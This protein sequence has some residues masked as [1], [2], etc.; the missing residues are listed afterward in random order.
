M[1]NFIAIN[2]HSIEYHHLKVDDSR[3]TLVFLHEGLGCIQMWRDFPDTVANATGCNLLVYN[4][5]GY[6]DSTQA[7]LPRQVRYMHDEA[8]DILPAVL[9]KLEIGKHIL[10]GHSDGGSIA[11]INGGGAASPN[12]LGIVT[13]AAHV[14][15]EAVCVRSIEEVKVAYKTTRLRGKLAKYHADVDNTFWGWNDI[16]LHPDFWHWNIEEYLP[17]IKVPLLIMQGLDDQYGTL[18][19]VEAIEKGVGVSAEISL[20][21]D[22]KHSPHHEQR[23]TTFTAIVDF[24]NT[25]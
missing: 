9:D 10:V 21:P 2:E 18:A 14:F 15:N 22:C 6:G 3:P 20:I 1:S 25:L 23:D 11:L 12:L 13:L 5:A 19:Q 16:W 24:I 17:S 8:L 4:R 7:K